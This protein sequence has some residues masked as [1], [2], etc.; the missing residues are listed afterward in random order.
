MWNLVEPQLLTVEPLYIW[1]LVEPELLTV[2]PLSP[3]SAEQSVRHDAARTA[4]MPIQQFHLQTKF[5]QLPK[6]LTVR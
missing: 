4:I 3:L 1:N 2:E 5:G 6:K